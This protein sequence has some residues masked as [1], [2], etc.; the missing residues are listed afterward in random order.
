MSIH[1]GAKPGEIAETILLPEDPLRAK[2]IAEHFLT[3]AV[4]YNKIRGMYGFTG[5]FR[6]EKIS[7]QGT[8]MGIPSTAIYINELIQFYG[9]KNLI[10][11]GT[12]GGIK[13]KIHI[14]DLVLAMTAS[15]DSAF[16]TQIAP[17]FHFSPTADF[18]LLKTAYEIASQK[19]KNIH[20]GNVLTA[21]SFYR[22]HMDNV[23]QLGEYNVLAVEMET[24][25]LYTL[26]NKHHVRALTILTVSDHI[27]T[28][29]ETDANERETSF[30]DMIEI[31]LETA[32]QIQI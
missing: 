12:C 11:V 3:D 22:D 19:Q 7:V 20:V 15:T 30:T 32:I 5:L 6:G 18:T 31:A 24:T 2:F 17:G 14:R 23:K 21:D 26:A 10:R 25:A 4:C 1:I 28:G 16:T 27:F 9:T 29:E 8:G 13:E